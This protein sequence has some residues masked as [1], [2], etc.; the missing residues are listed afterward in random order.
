M[1]IRQRTFRLKP[2]NAR[3]TVAFTHQEVYDLTHDIMPPGLVAAVY[4]SSV[5]DYV[6][7][8][9]NGIEEHTIW[10]EALHI[11]LTMLKDSDDDINP[12]DQQELVCYTQGYV[13]DEIYKVI[14][15]YNKWMAKQEK[16]E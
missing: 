10:H 4:H 1:N 7:A 2:Y 9:P 11:V 14:D 6:L 15:K 16:A 12:C 8:L 3:V 5:F 13:V